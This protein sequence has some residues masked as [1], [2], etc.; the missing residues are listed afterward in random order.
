[1]FIVPPRVNP[2]PPRLTGEARVLVDVTRDWLYRLA[3]EEAKQRLMTEARLGARSNEAAS[4][5]AR[6]QLRKH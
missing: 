2:Y 6:S 4:Q 5:E 1:M 3:S